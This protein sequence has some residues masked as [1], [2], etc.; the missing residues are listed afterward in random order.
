M[1]VNER[2]GV[3]SSYQVTSPLTAGGGSPAV[4]IAAIAASGTALT[5]VTLTSY[6]AAATAFGAESNMAKLVRLLLRNGAPEVVAVP[7]SIG[8]TPSAS[9]YAA[10]FAVLMADSAVRYMVCDSRAAAV[11]A[12]L[13]SA[14]E[15]AGSELCK[16]RVGFVEASGSVAE[17]TAKAAAMNCE[18][19]VLV[20]G[21]ETDGVPGSVAAA[22]AAVVAAEPDPARPFNGAELSGVGAVS[23][24]FTDAQI[25]TLVQG[26]V[27]PV[28]TLSGT[29][30]VVRAVTTRAATGGVADP[31]WRELGTVL[32]ADDVITTVRDSLRRRFTRTKNTA[33]TRGAIRTQ[34]VIELEAKLAAAVI[35]GYGDVTAAADGSDPTVCVVGFEFTVAHG[36]NRIELTAYITV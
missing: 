13:E 14:I 18:R 30:S 29:V 28:E 4:G 12:E 34:V 10:A 7:V 31:T 5:A 27:T 17:L 19:M 11:H 22:M 6:A 3:Y 36:L 1:S 20:S 21:V 2:P 9:D 15:G 16:Y 25:T 33:Q 35:D 26:G 24:L 8:G 23:A 32:I